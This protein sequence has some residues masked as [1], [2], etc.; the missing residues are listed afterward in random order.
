VPAD[1]KTGEYQIKLS[2]VNHPQTPGG[3]AGEGTD[4]F[5]CYTTTHFAFLMGTSLGNMDI[6]SPT[7]TNTQDCVKGSP[8][9]HVGRAL[10]YFN[11]TEHTSQIQISMS[12]LNFFL[13]DPSGNVYKYGSTQTVKHKPGMWAIGTDIGLENGPG[14]AGYCISVK[15]VKPLFSQS[16]QYYYD[17]PN[18]SVS[19]VI[20]NFGFLTTVNFSR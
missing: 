11:V 6:V 15:G 19:Q 12:R 20:R 16:P 18:Q 1:G 8:Y 10:L 17:S 2:A 3:C 9:A 7:I 13:L 5:T 14:P 4:R